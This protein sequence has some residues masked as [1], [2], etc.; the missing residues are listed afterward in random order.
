MYARATHEFFFAKFG[1]ETS[2]KLLDVGTS[3]DT[4]CDRADVDKGRIRACSFPCSLDVAFV[5]SCFCPFCQNLKPTLLSY[6]C[7]D[8]LSLNRHGILFAFTYQ[9]G[10]S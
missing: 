3:R 2:L 6:F 1:S 10:T 8:I 9:F 7:F 5:C 4:R